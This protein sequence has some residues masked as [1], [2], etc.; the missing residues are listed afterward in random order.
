M[1]GRHV[2]HLELEAL[3][4][5]IN[6]LEGRVGLYRQGEGWDNDYGSW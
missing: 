3:G 6:I 5:Y 4:M 1:E 2:S